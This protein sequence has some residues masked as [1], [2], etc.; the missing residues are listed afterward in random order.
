MPYYNKTSRSSSFDSYYGTF[1]YTSTSYYSILQDM[2]RNNKTAKSKRSKTERTI[3]SNNNSCSVDKRSSSSNSDSDQS[4]RVII[5]QSP[6]EQT[7]IETSAKQSKRRNHSETANQTRFSIDSPTHHPLEHTKPENSRY[8]FTSSLGKGT[9]G[10]VRLAYDNIKDKQ[11]AVKTIK[12]TKIQSSPDERRVQREITIAKLLN[13]NNIITVHDVLE[14]PNHIWI[15]MEYAAHGELYELLITNGALPSDVARDIFKQILSAVHHC[16]SFGVI[17][18]DLKLENILVFDK[19]RKLNYTTGEEKTFYTIK[20]ADFGLANTVEHDDEDHLLRT[21]CGSLLYAAPEVVHG[22]PYNGPKV[23]AW[24]LGVVL[25]ALVYGA[26]PF[27]H[28]VQSVLLEQ[29]S[30]GDFYRHKKRHDAEDLIE[31]LLCVDPIERGS[32]VDAIDS[33]WMNVEE[34]GYFDFNLTKDESV[35][36][37][38]GEGMIIDEEKNDAKY[39]EK[40]DEKYDEKYAEKYDQKYDVKYEDTFE[41]N[42]KYDENLKHDYDHSDKYSEKYPDKYSDTF[43]EEK[44][45]HRYNTNSDENSKSPGNSF[46]SPPK[47]LHSESSSNFLPSIDSGL[48]QRSGSSDRSSDHASDHSSEVHSEHLA[49]STNPFINIPTT[50]TGEPDDF[51]FDTRNLSKEEAILIKRLDDSYGFGNLKLSDDEDDHN[52]K[53]SDFPEIGFPEHGFQTHT[54]FHESFQKHDD[55]RDYQASSNS[56]NSST[57]KTKK[58]DSE[59]KT[60]NFQEKYRS[61]IKTSDFSSSG[62]EVNQNLELSSNSAQNLSFLSLNSSSSDSETDKSTP[63]GSKTFERLDELTAMMSSINKNVDSFLER[64]TELQRNLDAICK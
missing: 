5:D 51:A 60:T 49:N 50:K 58:N 64:A 18:R 38:Y 54:K 63:S 17:H 34:D 42:N 12:K 45:V 9:Y 61:G 25:Y 29:I 43:Y 35:D 27:E 22:R 2:N 6:I 11:V 1:N 46:S 7:P 62:S 37:F 24:A 3:D 14:K 44:I 33:E 31:R 47:S 40:Y 4:H 15:V 16:H 21:F 57:P 41:K 55:F 39:M 8:L 48:K 13:H 52:L 30:K 32:V 23:D 26:M 56:S 20:L 19:H 59:A 28:T 10:H 53:V 36:N